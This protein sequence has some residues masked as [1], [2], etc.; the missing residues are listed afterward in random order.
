MSQEDTKNQVNVNTDQATDQAEN[1][2]VEPKVD[3]TKQDLTKLFNVGDTVI[4]NYKI[5]EG[6]KSRIQPYEGIVIAKKGAGMSKTFTVRRIGAAAIGVERIFPLY[7][8][9]IESITV[10]S[11]GKV[12]RA[13]LYYMRDRIG[14]AARKVKE[15]I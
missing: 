13:K 6:E 14:K 8:P 9:N 2:V 5:I 4:V 11:K 10:K 1:V 15:K 3:A 7:S 12:R